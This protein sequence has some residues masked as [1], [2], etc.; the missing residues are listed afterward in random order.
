[1]ALAGFTERFPKSRTLILGKTEISFLESLPQ[2]E[3]EVCLKQFFSFDI[4]LIIITKALKP[5]PH[6]LVEAAANNVP[7]LQSNLNTTEIMIRLSTYLDNVFAPRTTIHGT[8][9]DVYGVGLLYTGKSGIGKS[10]CAL[11]LIERGH[12]LVADDVV[13]V[14]R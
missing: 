13:S 12:R 8:L 14:V 11:D 3:L 10:E 1:M 4:P 7:I 5:P 6:F 2:S 9:V